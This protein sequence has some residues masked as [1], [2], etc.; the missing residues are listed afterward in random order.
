MAVFQKYRGC[1]A[2]LP[3]QTE[4]FPNQHLVTIRSWKECKL[5]MIA[6]YIDVLVLRALCILRVEVQRRVARIL[7]KQIPRGQ[8]PRGHILS[9]GELTPSQL[10]MD[11][12]VDARLWNRPEL[13]SIYQ[14]WPKVA[15]WNGWQNLSW[16]V[17]VQ[18]FVSR[19]GRVCCKPVL[20]LKK[21]DQS[22]L[23]V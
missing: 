11:A 14:S 6:L 9:F 20:L 17:H 18:T 19:F 4:T 7:T 1:G 2:Y 8:N 3:D 22:K 12:Y 13:D 23:K 5:F 10:I 21:E 16:H 15:D